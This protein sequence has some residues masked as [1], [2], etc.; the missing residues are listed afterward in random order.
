M[1]AFLNSLWAV[2]GL[3]MGLMSFMYYL[4]KCSHRIDLKNK[5]VFI[6]G[7]SSGLGEAC[8]EA[9]YEAGCKLVLS[10]RKVQPLMDLKDR[11]LQKNI[12]G[13]SSPA[14]VTIDLENLLSIA[15]KMNQVVAAFGRVDIIINNAGQS[16]RGK[17]NDTKLDVD[18]KLMN[19][20]YFGQIEITKAILPHMIQQQYGHIVAISSV[21]GK[22]S[23]PH[24][25]A[26]AASKHALQAYFDCLRAEVA[27][28]N[29]SV[30]VVSPYYISTNLSLNALTGDGSSYGKVDTTTKSGLKP[31]YVASEIVKCVTR[32]VDELILA[33]FHVQ[34][35]ICLRTLAPWLFFQ[36]MAS[37]AK[38]ESAQYSKNS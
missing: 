32:K 4:F 15:S 16:Y 25:S 8:A 21:Q 13:S 26:Y 19:I 9:F 35:A 22:I 34:L 14:I 28:Y 7:A 6:T 10:G 12:P 37:R 18:V 27:Q 3:P 30:C 1:Y 2:I 24:R 17:A 38:K 29:I 33:P 23:I 20:N 11:L 36:I 31:E 5:V